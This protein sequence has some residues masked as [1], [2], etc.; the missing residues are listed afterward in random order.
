MNAPR[1][2]M[3]SIRPFETRSAVANSWNVRTGSAVLIDVEA[4][5]QPDAPV[6]AAIAESIVAVAEFT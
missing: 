1:P 2:K 4:L 6:T 5:G 3:I